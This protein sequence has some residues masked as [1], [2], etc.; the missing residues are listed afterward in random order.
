VNV[1][2]VNDC[3]GCGKGKSKCTECLSLCIGLLLL[4]LLLFHSCIC[5]NGES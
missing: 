3:R 1:K 2:K 5:I 4:L